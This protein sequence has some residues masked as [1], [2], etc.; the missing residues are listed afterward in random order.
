MIK[1]IINTM[2]ELMKDK[3]YIM[4]AIIIPI[5]IAIFFSF[6]FTGQHKFKI[7][8]I[9]NDNSYLSN[10]IIKTIDDLEGIQSIKIKKD[11]SEILLITQQIQMVV[12]INDNFQNKLINSKDNE[13]KIKT[14]NENDVKLVVQNMIDMK[15]EDLS[16]IGKMSKG[17]INKFKE[18]NQDYN[19]KNTILSLNDVNEK[20]PDIESSLPLI[21]L[22][23]FIVAGKVSNSLIEDKENKVRINTPGYRIS[24]WKYYLSIIVVFYIMSSMSTLI[25]YG[26]LIIFKLDFAMENSINFLVVMLMLNLVALSFNLCLV[27]FT[28]SRHT[29]SM[30]N[31]LII[32][33]C[34]MLSGVF[35]D[36]NIMNENFQ[37]IGKL[38]P[39]RWVYICLENLQKTNDLGSINIYLNAMLILSIILF[40]ISFVKLKE[41]KEV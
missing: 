2:R 17:D 30:L 37:A 29:S 9:D 27:S 33:P 36:F 41:N 15:C 6:E 23:I 25:Y 14:I 20:R 40:V 19:D 7:G 4:V 3:S 1:L 24:K 18:I 28:R 38:M 39:T 11:D 35:W 8:V 22:I 12:I 13:I 5:F 32:V 26:V 16:M 31:V 34:C 10:E 21:I